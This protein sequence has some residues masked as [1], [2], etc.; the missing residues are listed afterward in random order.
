MASIKD[1]AKIAGVS[2]TTVSRVLNNRG[3]LSDDI[4]KR[5]HD[6]MKEL[7]Y[8]PNQIARALQNKDSK[9]FAILIPDSTNPFFSELLK[10]VENECHINGY[11][12]I[13]CNSEDNPE[14]EHRYLETLQGQN[15]DG[16]IVCSHLLSLEAYE[17]FPFPMVSFEKYILPNIPVISSNNFEG[18]IIAAKQL[19]DKGCKKLLHISGPLSDIS[20]KGHDRLKGFSSYCKDHNITPDV[21]ETDKHFSY[22]YYFNYLSNNIKKETFDYDGVF[23]SNDLIA[24]AFY[25]V[26]KSMNISIP[27]QCKIIGFDYS[28]FTKILQEPKIT[29]IAQDLPTISKELIKALILQRKDKQN[30]NNKIIPVRL[31]LGNTI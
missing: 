19:I 4:K 27:E 21:L 8:Q 17:F 15:I 11:R 20:L 10:L 24:Y 7:H 31:V 6:A 9:L 1:V 30:I 18:G 14:K 16:L 13:I 2:P 3:Y 5:V 28:L 29:T 26:A 22:E 23:C 25:N 12:L